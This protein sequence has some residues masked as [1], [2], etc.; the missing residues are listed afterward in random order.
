MGVKVEQDRL[1]PYVVPAYELRRAL[2]LAR[3][4]E[5]RFSVT[6]TKMPSELRTPT[7]WRAYRGLAVTVVDGDGSQPA[8]CSTRDRPARTVVGG[9]DGV[10]AGECDGASEPGMQPPP[11]YLLTKLLH[12]YPIP[13]IAEGGDGIFCST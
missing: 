6:Y 4:Q 10:A 1:D 12:P 11:R 2:G 3:A 7:E 9:D 8:S 13:L 5:A